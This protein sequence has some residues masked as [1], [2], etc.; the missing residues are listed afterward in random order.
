MIKNILCGL[1]GSTFGEVAC[2]YALDLSLRLDAQLEAVHVVDSRMLDFPLIAPQS[3]VMAW[4]P[5]V[6]NGLMEALR[7]RGATILAAAAK[8]AEAAGIAL[9]TSLEFGH[10]AQV[11]GEVQCRT[12]LL[13]VGRQGE[14][15]QSA[16]DM[17]GSTMERLVRRACR[18]CLVTPAEFR[19]IDKI[20]IGVDGSAASG[21]ALK[22]TVELAN[23]LSAPLVILAVADREEDVPT[24]RQNAEDAHRLARAHDC[25]AASMTAVG[26]AATRILEKAQELDCSLIALGSHG[27]G[28]IYDRLI[29]GTAAHVASRAATPVLLVR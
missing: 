2:G 16:P 20:L 10:P 22:E 21:R 7:E 18:P 13:V 1:D 27:H 5:G 9:V 15:A 12:E 24:A 28:W 23:A 26:P 29:G 6:A 25:A 14:H 4:S 11:L 3:G 8:R 19:A 17:T